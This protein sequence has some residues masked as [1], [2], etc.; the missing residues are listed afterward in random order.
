ME[1]SR[2]LKKRS[3]PPLVYSPLVYSPSNTDSIQLPLETKPSNLRGK[4][5]AKDSDHPF[6]LIGKGFVDPMSKSLGNQSGRSPNE[7]ETR[8][9]PNAIITPKTNEPIKPPIYSEYLNKS[10]VKTPAYRLPSDEEEIITKSYGKL[11]PRISSIEEEF[12]Q[13]QTEDERSLISSSAYSDSPRIYPYSENSPNESPRIDSSIAGSG[14]IILPNKVNEIKFST[15]GEKSLVKSSSM[16]SIPQKADENAEV[17]QKQVQYLSNI[18][19][20]LE[21]E[22]Q[23]RFQTM[24]SDMLTFSEQLS[25]AKVE[26]EG[27]KHLRQIEDTTLRNFEQR[28]AV[29]FI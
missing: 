9:K 12:K 1:P 16:D 10:V 24:Q 27:L 28:I 3:T 19:E 15:I 13:K 29:R 8:L 18:V 2:V 11:M 22:I 6:S 25:Q 17:I 20:R 7:E 26:N 21:G 14:N 5:P 4:N 23:R